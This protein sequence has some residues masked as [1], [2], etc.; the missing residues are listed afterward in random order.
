MKGAFSKGTKHPTPSHF[1]LLFNYS[2]PNSQE[3]E[4]SFLREKEILKEK[5]FYK[6]ILQVG[7][8]KQKKN[9]IWLFM[10]LSLR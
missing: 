8:R 2:I 1:T 3:V 10:V 5:G 6:D 7:G 9:R 4:H